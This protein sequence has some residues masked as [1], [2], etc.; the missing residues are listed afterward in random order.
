MSQSSSIQSI[1]SGLEAQNNLTAAETLLSPAMKSPIDLC[2]QKIE[3]PLGIMTIIASDSGLSFLEFSQD[4]PSEFEEALPANS[5][6]ILDKENEITKLTK[7]QLQEYFDRKR[8]CFDIPLDFIG[9]DFQKKVWESLLQIEF[10]KLSSYEDQSKMIGNPLAI[11]AMAHANGQNKIA[12]VVPCHRVIGKDGSMT[13]YAGG[14][15]R[16]EW[17]LDHEG[18][19]KKSLKLDL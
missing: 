3:T 12:I 17:L 1:N 16:K 10:G 11:R 4:N 14:I 7:I 19:V 9:T 13:G 6:R 2:S 15:W 5:Y 8:T 18:S